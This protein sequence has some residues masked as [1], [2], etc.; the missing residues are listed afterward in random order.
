MLRAKTKIRMGP[1]EGNQD[2]TAKSKGIVPFNSKF[3]RHASLG[4]M[5]APY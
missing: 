1:I 5:K 4:N 2:I 3:Y